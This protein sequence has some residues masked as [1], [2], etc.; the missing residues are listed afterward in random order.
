MS[1]SRSCHSSPG[2]CSLIFM[3][4]DEL[5]DRKWAHA[6]VV[7]WRVICQDELNY[8]PRLHNNGRRKEDVWD[9]DDIAMLIPWII[10]ATVCRPFIALI[11]CLL[12]TSVILSKHA[13][14]AP[15][16]KPY[17]GADDPGNEHGYVVKIPPVFLM[18]P[19]VVEPGTVV[20]LVSTYDSSIDHFGM[21][22][23]S[24]S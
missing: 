18:P 6:K 1:G 3:C 19:V 12:G 7:C 10:C 20:E 5:E 16:W 11:A 24:A 21:R 8:S 2:G 17:C 4:N 15:Y 13:I 22:P 23:C 14:S 9:D